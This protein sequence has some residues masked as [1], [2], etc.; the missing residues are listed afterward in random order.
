MNRFVF[1]LSLFVAFCIVT[2]AATAL[3]ISFLKNSVLSR[4]S[5]T[6]M[7]DFRAN[8]SRAL[9][10]AG[11][12]TVLTWESESGKFI[13]KVLF[14]ATYINNGDL[15]CRRVLFRIGEQDRVPE[16]YRFD[17]CNNEDQ[18]RFSETSVSSFTPAEWSYLK[19]IAI[20]TLDTEPDATAVSWFY[21]KTGNAGVITPL[22]T[23][24]RDGKK[25]RE[26][27]FSIISRSGDTFD[28]NYTFCKQE[29]GEWFLSERE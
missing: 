13:A 8:V 18:W 19:R 10:S 5:K 6:E 20:E 29:G 1:S 12:G 4:L 15:T 24:E 2:P 3:N 14:R 27:S 11:D 22:S 7:M 25:C 17:L 16:R 23:Q 28:G 21:R 9:I 26:A